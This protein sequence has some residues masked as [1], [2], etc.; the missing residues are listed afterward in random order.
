MS[1]GRELLELGG[2]ALRQVAGYHVAYL[3]DPVPREGEE[4]AQATRGPPEHAREEELLQS[5]QSGLHL[6]LRELLEEA[7]DCQ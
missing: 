1:L 7:H 5:G 6:D 2:L 4:V 3:L